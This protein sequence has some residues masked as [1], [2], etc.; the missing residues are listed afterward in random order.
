[1]RHQ[2][3]M[4]GSDGLLVGTKT[5]PRGAGTFSRYLGR[6]GREQQVLS[7]P[8]AIVHP[9]ALPARRLGLHDR[10]RIAVGAI[11]DLFLFD[12]DTVDER[13]TFAQP[14]L[15][16]AGIEHVLSRGVPVV[17]AGARTDALAVRALRSMGHRSNH[18]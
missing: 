6:Y 1:M 5:L 15:P 4:G 11:A 18:S 7:L 9:S 10:G 2:R 16:P 8:T 3:H 13:A 17:E 12:L 14:R